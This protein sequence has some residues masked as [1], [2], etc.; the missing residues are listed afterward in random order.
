LGGHRL[1]GERL[2]GA[3]SRRQR[4][5]RRTIESAAEVRN[6]T[7]HAGSNPQG[8]M[9]AANTRRQVSRRQQT[10]RERR[11]TLPAGPRSAVGAAPSSA[12][13][14]SAALPATAFLSSPPELTVLTVTS[15]APPA[16]ALCHQLLSASPH[17]LL[18]F[19]LPQ[20]EVYPA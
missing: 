3:V 4:P 17:P 2:G 7:Y 13:V 11:P 5:L 15:A 12:A 1:G 18:S 20:G 6:V 10:A 19:S 16:T 8:V 9:H 14:N